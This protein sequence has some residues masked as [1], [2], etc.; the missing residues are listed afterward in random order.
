MKTLGD[1][2]SRYK[3]LKTPNG[4]LRK[5][6]IESVEKILD[7]TLKEK[8]IKIQKTIISVNA[9]SVIKNEIRLNQKEIITEIHNELGENQSITA[10]F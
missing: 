7:I 10:I 2:L 1:L 9:P 8:D 4:T 3:N 5:V 6:F